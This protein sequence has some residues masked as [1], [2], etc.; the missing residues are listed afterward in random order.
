MRVD[1]G[2]FDFIAR[3]QFFCLKNADVRNILCYRINECT[4]GNCEMTK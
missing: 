1:K 2:K 4:L 3:M